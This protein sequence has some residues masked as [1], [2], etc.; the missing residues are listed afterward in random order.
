MKRFVKHECPDFAT[1][2]ALASS[3]H[4]PLYHISLHIQFLFG[5]D[6]VEIDEVMGKNINYVVYLLYRAKTYNMHTTH[7]EKILFSQ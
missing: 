5:V 3:D 6:R 7:V 2:G 1:G 4:A